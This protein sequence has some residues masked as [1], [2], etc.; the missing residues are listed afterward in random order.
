[1]NNIIEQD[2]RNIKKI[3]DN[4]LGFKHFRSACSTIQGIE[5]LS[6]IRKGQENTRT[7]LEEITLINVIFGVA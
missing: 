4:I 7:I 1:M 5:A 6:M 3:T 2:H